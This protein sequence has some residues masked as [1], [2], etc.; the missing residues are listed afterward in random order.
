MTIAVILAGGLGTR[1]RAAVPDLPK[2]MAEVNGKPFLE[3]LLNYWI[4]QG[5]SKFILSVGYKREII[6]NHFGESFKG[7]PIEYIVEKEPL[8]TGGAL[9]LAIVSI[10]HPFLLLNGDT[11]FE[12]HLDKF[13]NFHRSKKSKCSIVLFRANECGRY[14]GVKLNENDRIHSLNGTKSDIGELANGGVYLIDPNIFKRLEFKVGYKCSLEDDLIPSL[15]NTDSKFFGFENQGDFL[16]IG[17]PRD[18]FRAAAVLNK[19]GG[20]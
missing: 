7:I 8:G 10:E 13:L 6:I 17:V 1:L 4:R 3:Y 2:P 11:Y 18:Y 9:L 12:V 14:G 20:Y 19:I 5:V 15:L 16:D